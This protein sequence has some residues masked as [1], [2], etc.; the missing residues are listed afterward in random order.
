MQFTGF[1]DDGHAPCSKIFSG[2]MSRDTLNFWALNA[3]SCKMSRDTK[4]KFGIH[5]PRERPDM[6]FTE[7]FEEEA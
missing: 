2:V 4:F 5:A 6:T 3:N 7:I 1:R